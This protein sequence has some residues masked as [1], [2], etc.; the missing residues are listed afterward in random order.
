MSVIVTFRTASGN[1]STS[2][3]RFEAIT[4]EEQGLEKNKGQREIAARVAKKMSNFGSSGKA[5]RHCKESD[6]AENMVTR[7]KEE[8]V[9]TLQPVLNV[10]VDVGTRLLDDFMH[11]ATVKDTAIENTLVRQREKNVRQSG[12]ACSTAGQSRL[13]N[14]QEHFCD[15][16]HPLCSAALAD[17]SWCSTS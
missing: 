4:H 16:A 7:E 11:L 6:N 1:A 2:Q 8:F 15:T 9:S 17:I 14:S 3:G 5:I 13:E 12:P 10:F